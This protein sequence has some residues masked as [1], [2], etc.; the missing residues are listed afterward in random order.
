VERAHGATLHVSDK[1]GNAI[2][3][4]DGQQQPGSVSDEAIA[5]EWLMRAGGH[6][7]HE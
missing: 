3:D 2:S 6:A 7:V 5:Y 1:H 4:L